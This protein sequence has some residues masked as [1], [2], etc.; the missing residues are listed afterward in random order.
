MCTIAYSNSIFHQNQLT[1]AYSRRATVK[2]LRPLSSTLI[3]EQPEIKE[4]N[5]FHDENDA[6]LFD[7]ETDW[8]SHAKWEEAKAGLK[9]HVCLSCGKRFSN[10]TMKR[11]HGVL[12]HKSSL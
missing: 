5:K 11:I 4:D 3:F 6:D 10:K 9:K 12:K 2:K 7:V 1:P 8:I